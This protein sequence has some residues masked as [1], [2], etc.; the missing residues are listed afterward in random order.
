MIAGAQRRKGLLGSQT[1]SVIVTPV[2][3]VFAEITS[4]MQKDAVREAA[5]EAKR[6]GKGL[7]GRMAA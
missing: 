7:L 2:R 1:F 5:E 3:L 4:Q 6:E